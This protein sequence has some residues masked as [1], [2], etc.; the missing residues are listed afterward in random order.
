[1]MKHPALVLLSAFS[2]FAA[3]QLTAQASPSKYMNPMVPPIVGGIEANSGE[4]PFIV[5]MQ[6]SGFGHFCG[7]S[8][9]AKNWV[10][11]AAHCMEDGTSGVTL[12]LGLQKLTDTSGVEKFTISQ[13]VTH[14]Q[15]NSKTHDYDFALVKLSGN[16]KLKPVAL[17]TNEISIPEQ[18]STAPHAITAG[19]GTTSESG[20]I[21]QTLLKVDVPLVSQARCNEA[22]PDAM[23]DRMICAGYDA[24]QKDSCQGDSGGPLV[25]K[26]SSGATV[27]AGVVGWGEGCAEPKKYGVYGK[28]NSVASWVTQTSLELN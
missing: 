5:S 6:L 11:T 28:V 10:L 22:Y 20:A 2:V 14:P 21:S 17:N 25:V 18:E 4:F 3:L 12:V 15:Y 7:G 9:V 26:S 24:G 1:M 23:T 13:V 8:L 16:S 19:W 27:L